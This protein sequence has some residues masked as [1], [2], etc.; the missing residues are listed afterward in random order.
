MDEITHECQGQES[1]QIQQNH[2]FFFVFPGQPHTSGCPGASAPNKPHKHGY[3]V[4]F[5]AIAQ[6]G[7][8][9]K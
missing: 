7:H 5:R 4:I 3:D 8:D 6:S 1:D 2:I 9:W